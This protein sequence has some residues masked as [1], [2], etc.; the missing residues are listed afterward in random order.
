M[1]PLLR[2]LSIGASAFFLLVLPLRLSKL[3]KE[4]I[5]IIPEHGAYSKLVCSQGVAVLLG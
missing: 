3:H 1:Y 5:K 4:T 2:L